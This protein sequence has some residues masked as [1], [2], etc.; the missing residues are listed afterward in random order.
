MGTGGEPPPWEVRYEEDE[1]EATAQLTSD[2]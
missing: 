2:R 1:A